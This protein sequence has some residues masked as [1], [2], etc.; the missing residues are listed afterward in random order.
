[1]PE[2]IL[3]VGASIAGLTTA[4]WLARHGFEPVVV[5]RAA[6]PRR[7]GNGVDLRGE[8]VAIVEAMGILPEV[9]RS[10]ADV[11]GMKFVDGDDRTIA[12]VHTGEPG[13]F[14]VMRG[15]LVGMLRA[16][17]AD[18]RFG[19]SPTRIEQDESGVAVSFTSG[20]VERFALVIGADGL[21]STVRR[22]VFGPEED[23]LRFRDHYFAFGDADASLGEDR[24]VTM[25][26]V[27]GKMAG[28][29]RSGNHAQ[30]KAYLTFRAPRNLG[31]LTASDERRMLTEAFADVASWHTQ[32][33]LASV[34]SDDGRYVDALAQV[35]MASW[36]R[37]RVTLVGDAAW[38]ASPVAGA[39][40]ELAIVGAYRLANALAVVDSDRRGFAAGLARY[41]SRMR[42][43]VVQKQ[44]IG[45]NVRLMVPATRFGIAARNVVARSGLPA[46]LSR[47]QTDP[48]N[49]G[50]SPA[51]ER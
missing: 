19:D 10:A 36:I 38:C 42:A 2:R 6:E 20:T 41:E 8:A 4:S 35:R 27:P 16:L 18:I 46:L 24:W 9:R 12:R 5:E 1:M 47:F 40:A 44:R 28:I 32:E 14:E 51:P 50:T 23:F 48:T 21:H 26:N 34:L 37:G 25:H 30:A 43:M 22:L 45:T 15:D 29:Y 11:L 49:P 17:V 13:A 39:G 7:G 33:I 31:R 3:I